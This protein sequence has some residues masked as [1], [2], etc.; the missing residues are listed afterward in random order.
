MAVA[1]S[2][3]LDAAD[4]VGGHYIAVGQ[5]I[6]GSHYVLALCVALRATVVADIAVFGRSSAITRGS[7]SA[8]VFRFVVHGPILCKPRPGALCEVGRGAEVAPRATRG[9]GVVGFHSLVATEVVTW[10][11]LH[12]ASQ[13]A[14]SMEV[15]DVLA[16][17]TLV[18]MHC[19]LGLD[20]S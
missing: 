2:V 11:V 18:V 20:R 6:G 19:Y 13:D 16:G 5:S 3:C 1:R 12:D 17:A 9:Y 15:T 7:A 10:A 4:Y 8:L 14:S